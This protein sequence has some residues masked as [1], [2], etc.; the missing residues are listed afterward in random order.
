LVPIGCTVAHDET[1]QVV[2]VI[3]LL[4]HFLSQVPFVNLPSKVWHVDSSV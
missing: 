4:I 3:E 2:G 1:L